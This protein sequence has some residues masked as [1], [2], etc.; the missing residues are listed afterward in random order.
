MGL[1]VVELKR[2]FRVTVEKGQDPILLPD[3]NPTYTPE[4][5]LDHYSN[6]YPKL[7][8]SVVL[9]GI[10]GT[11]GEMIFEVKDNFGDKG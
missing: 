1:K 6:D 4:E 11:E 10:E 2:V 9:P 3:P 7:H 8:T 5:V